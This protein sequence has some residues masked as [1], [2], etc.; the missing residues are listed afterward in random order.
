MLNA[1]FNIFIPILAGFGV[2]QT[3]WVHHD[4]QPQANRFLM[5]FFSPFVIALSFWGL[6]FK[7]HR[8]LYLPLIG[9]LIT[10]LSFFPALAL[11][12]CLKLPR[13]GMGSFIP[14]A[15]FANLGFYGGYI[16]FERF[17]QLGY[18]LVSLYCVFFAPIYYTIGFIICENFSSESP[19]PN[20]GKRFSLL[21]KRDIVFRSLLGIVIGFILGQ[22]GPKRPEV[23]GRLVNHLIPLLTWTYLFLAGLALHPKSMRPY[24]KTSLW[25]SAL[26]F[27]FPLLVT[28]ILIPVFRLTD[29]SLLV[30]RQVLI[31]EAICPVGVSVIVLPS[32]FRVD[33]ELASTVWLVSHLV[34]F[35]LVLPFYY[36]FV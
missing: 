17:G 3:R 13:K 12:S 8:L 16:A 5:R 9:L 20:W 15:M 22:W 24:L 25:L 31:L 2:R 27:T 32:L 21:L 7:D 18:N 28:L 6:D 35:F 29:P 34:G 19:D 33:G 23:L 26:K 10:L 4:F 30:A 1:F 11:G 36:W 14:A